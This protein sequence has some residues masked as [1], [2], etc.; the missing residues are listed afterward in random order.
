MNLFGVFDISSAGMSVEQAQLAIAASN[1]ANSRTTQAE[2]GSVFR[3]L[4][5]VLRATSQPTSYSTIAQQLDAAALPR[6]VVADVVPSDAAPRLVY[7]PGHPEANAQGFV[8]YPAVDPLT[9]MLDLMTI[10]RSYEANL[11]AFDITRTLIQRTLEIG[12][13]R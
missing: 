1:L 2:D 11:R 8:S 3:P 13:G 5:V 9:T 7:D 4:N 10:S 12:R 6:P